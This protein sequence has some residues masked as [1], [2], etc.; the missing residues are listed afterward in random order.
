LLHYWASDVLLLPP[1]EHTF[2]FVIM[3]YGVGNTAAT[4]H[5][6]ILKSDSDKA[7]HLGVKVSLMKLLWHEMTEM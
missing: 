1:A 3:M 4:E 6:V 7:V 5:R 2:L